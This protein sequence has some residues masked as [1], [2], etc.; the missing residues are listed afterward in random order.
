MLRVYYEC[1]LLNLLLELVPVFIFYII[2]Q[3]INFTSHA[4]FCIAHNLILIN[5]N[6]NLLYIDETF[7][8]DNDI[9]TL[10]DVWTL[11][12]FLYHHSASHLT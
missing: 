4:K 5:A 9:L 1:L 3:I 8:A 10:Y 2:V 11:D 12:F 7:Y 6:Y